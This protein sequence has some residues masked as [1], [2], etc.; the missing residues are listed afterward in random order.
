MSKIA[1]RIA[2][3]HFRAIARERGERIAYTPARTTNM[4]EL[5]LLAA[6]SEVEEFGDIDAA[7]SA[8][9]DEWIADGDEFARLVG[10]LPE[11]GDVIRRRQF[12]SDD[13]IEEGTTCETYLVTRGEHPRPWRPHGRFGLIKIRTTLQRD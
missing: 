9:F 2:K 1:R 12:E 10:R 3:Q 8:I 5:T 13:P 6:R 4:I 7:Q 11:A